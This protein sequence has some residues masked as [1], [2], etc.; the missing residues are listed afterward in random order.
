MHFQNQQ[1]NGNADHEQDLFVPFGNPMVLVKKL[2]VV[3]KG[4]A[5]CKQ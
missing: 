2:E 5:E 1:A 4:A 3:E